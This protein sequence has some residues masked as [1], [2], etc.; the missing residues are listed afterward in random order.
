MFRW[1]FSRWGL[2]VSWTGFGRSLI[3]DCANNIFL[4]IFLTDQSFP[5]ARGGLGQG[6][7]PLAPQTLNTMT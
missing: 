3:A 5:L 4:F 7:G 1:G 2:A 6:W